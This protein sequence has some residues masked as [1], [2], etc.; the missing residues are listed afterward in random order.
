[1]TEMTPF[2]RAISEGRDDGPNA[3]DHLA[4]AFRL[5]VMK[6]VD[7]EGTPEEKA[8]RFL[9]LMRARQ[10]AVDS[11]VQA[12]AKGD[13]D[14]GLAVESFNEAVTG[15]PSKDKSRAFSKSITETRQ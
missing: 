14:G 2:S 1:M 5:T 11:M 12:T 15:R 13:D 7:G 3:G 8:K 6:I 9:A 10:A 4:N